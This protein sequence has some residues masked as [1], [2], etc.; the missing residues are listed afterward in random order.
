MPMNPQTYKYPLDLRGDLS[1]NHVVNEKHVVSTLARFIV[2]HAGAFYN[3]SLVISYNGETLTPKTDYFF[4]R[5]DDE[6]TLLSGKSVSR[7]IRIN[8]NIFQGEVTI[9]YQCVG[10]RFSTHHS[11]VAKLISEMK[12]DVRGIHWGDIIDLLR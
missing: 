10:E 12:H 11:T 8:R 6:A 5:I 9:S 3:D 4:S 2:P 7:L 1:T